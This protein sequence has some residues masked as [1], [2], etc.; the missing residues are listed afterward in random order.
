M[1]FYENCV[2]RIWLWELWF[3]K[4]KFRIIKFLDIKCYSTGLRTRIIATDFAAMGNYESGFPLLFSDIGFTNPASLFRVWECRLFLCLSSLFCA[5]LYP[6]FFFFFRFFNLLLYFFCLFFPVNF[7]FSLFF[8]ALRFA[9]LVYAREFV[10]DSIS[11][12]GFS[13]HLES[14]SYFFRLPKF[15][16][17][18]VA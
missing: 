7:L 9:T 1:Y 18:I 17:F 2:C 6:I 11:T 10:L 15:F 16:I 5:V 12:Y 13:P 3:A 4:S 14:S 8:P